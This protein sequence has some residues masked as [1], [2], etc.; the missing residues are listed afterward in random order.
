VTPAAARVSHSSDIRFGEVV[1]PHIAAGR[2]LARSLTGSRMDSEDIVQEAC[3]RAFRAL[4]QFRG[5]NPRAWVLTIVRHTA[6][7]WMRKQRQGPELVADVE[8]IDDRFG[9]LVEE[10]TPESILLQEQHS[11]L[12]HHAVVSLPEHFRETLRLR[13]SQ[14][15]TYQEIADCIGVPA[16]TVMSRLSRAHRRLSVGM[17]QL[18]QNR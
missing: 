4:N 1:R 9:R 5:T 12:L 15:L 16:G 13:Y 7:D 11:Q 3:L 14:D 6:F 18:S 2:A 10:V 8:Q 17:R